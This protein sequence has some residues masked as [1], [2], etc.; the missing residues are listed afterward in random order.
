MMK[1]IEGRS[2]DTLFTSDGRRIGRLD[3]VFK[4]NLPL[5]EAQ[6]IQERLDRVRVRYVPAQGFHDRSTD[7]IAGE[8]IARMGRV[9]VVFEKVDAVPRLPNGKFRSVICEI[10]AEHR[11]SLTA[12]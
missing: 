5:R 9:E 3:P 2:D 12:Q 8:L 4:T 6:I 11:H 7:S 10:P 1:S